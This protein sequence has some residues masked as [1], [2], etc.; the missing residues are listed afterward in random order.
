VR[1]G[2]GLADMWPAQPNHAGGQ[3]ARGLVTTAITTTIARTSGC[4]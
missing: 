2:A 1:R 4:L 3:R